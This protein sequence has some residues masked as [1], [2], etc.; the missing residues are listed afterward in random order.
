MTRL[1]NT[2][3]LAPACLSFHTSLQSAPGSW[4]FSLSQTGRASWASWA[5]LRPRG[6]VWFNG[7]SLRRPRPAAEFHERPRLSS[8]GSGTKRTCLRGSVSSWVFT[9][10]TSLSLATVISAS[11]VP[12]PVL[13]LQQSHR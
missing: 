7:F 3:P 1:S 2:G 12:G 4:D 13:A 10:A 9:H 5:G 8:A 6:C 11:Q